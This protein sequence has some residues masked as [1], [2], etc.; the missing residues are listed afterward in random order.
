VIERE[1]RILQMKRLGIILILFA[2]CSFNL[3]AQDYSVARGRE[4]L[5]RG[6]YREA[7]S[8][9]A[10]LL[11]KNPDWL[12]AQRGLVRAQIEVGNY[13]EAEARIKQYLRARPD[14][15]LLRIE[16][17]NVLFETG[18]YRE[19]ASEFEQV[20]RAAKGAAWLRASLM[21]ARSLLAQGKESEAR[22]L[23]EEFIRYSNS[24]A[25]RSAE[26]LTLIA[27]AITYLEKFKDANELYIDA[28][29]LDPNFIEAYLGQGELLNE[30]YNYGEA[31]S[32]FRDALKINP[33]SADARVGLAESLRFESGQ[34]ASVEVDRALAINPNHVGA[35]VL[36]AWLDLEADQQ[37][38]A[39]SRIE[40]ALQV[41]P[42]SIKAIALR[43]SIAYLS[44]NKDGL[45]AQIKRAL[46]ARRAGEFFEVLA[47]FAMINRRY[48]D[49]VEF[50][51]RAVELSPRLWRAR[52]EL[53]IGLLR[54]GREAEGR[55]ELE[56][57]FAGDPFNV[58]AKNTLD[59]LDSMRDYREVV[60]GQFLIK[61]APKDSEVISI[62]AA[63]LLE[64]AHKKLSAR[65]KFTP[66]APIVV[67]IFPNHEDFAVRSLGLPGLG[68]LGVCFGQV[69]AIDSPSAREAGRFNWG[70]TLWHEFT[71]VI[72]LQMSDHR[73][74]RWFSEGLSVLEERR[75]R[76][77][78]GDNWSLERLN[79]VTSGRFVSVND[80]DA[81]FMRPR[82]PDQVPLAYFQ[83]SLVCE[84]IEERFGFDAILKMLALYKQGAKTAEVF[85]RA[86]G[87]KLAE[88][89]RAFAD[90]LRAEVAPYIKAV[91]GSAQAYQAA[92]KEALEAVLK[93]RPED[94]FAHLK[95]G[96]IYKSEGDN[97]RAIEHFKQAAANFPFYA[98][99]GNPYLQLADIYES[100]ARKAEAA[101]QLERLVQV[102]ETGLDALK[103]LARLRLEM[104]DR[105]AAL[106]AL[107]A[108]FYI[109]PFDARLHKLAGDAY[110]EEGN[111]SEA[112]R[113]FR[114]VVALGPPDMAGAYYDL[115]RSLLAA[116]RRAEARRELL[117]S[118]EIAP[119]FEKAQELL[120]K[121]KG[122]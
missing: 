119:G 29:Q 87:M 30:K 37:Q 81:A 60:R 47:H 10:A 41:N 21:R 105:A 43:A 13:A 14:D 16:M 101:A 74:P 102:D 68:A 76:P 113:E 103:R 49:A 45:E 32:L 25:P 19:A 38:A 17:G 114:I 58:W 62:Y 2:G 28:R 12:E 91:S 69:I 71:H 27:K 65:Y 33:N 51:R 93:A 6:D 99:E 111:A 94:Y 40:Q 98:G 89:D 42:N 34:E 18:R 106:E 35:L 82:A 52:T 3:G 11:A 70:S 56:R 59:L 116:G 9:F 66:R 53:G 117:R 104:N 26:E 7:I 88:F 107:K 115:A 79:A 20:A 84:Y 50:A 96:S 85:E 86:L 67:E 77:G 46:A 108:I 118:L 83:A 39:S 75:A 121:L 122:N 92:T 57:A 22:P 72:T 100:Q 90:H 44:D 97:E 4:L 120:L 5:G 54:I 64:E 55:A 23:L 1:A 80:L 24:N 61:C 110:L 31:A 36:R 112:A 95:L 109:Y 48:Q 8:V 73:I 15:Q 63:D 78:W